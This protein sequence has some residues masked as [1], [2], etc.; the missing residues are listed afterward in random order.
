MYPKYFENKFENKDSDLVAEIVTGSFL[1]EMKLSL[2]PAKARR[3][4]RLV[5]QREMH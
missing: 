1:E 5:N 4:P 3:Q 2:P